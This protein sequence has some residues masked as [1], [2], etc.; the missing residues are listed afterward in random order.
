M[1]LTTAT[2]A[3][4]PSRPPLFPLGHLLAT[5]QVLSVLD[6]HGIAPLTLLQ[7]HVQ[8]DWGELV[9]EDQQV[10]QEALREGARLL[11][12]YHIAPGITVWIITEADRSVTNLLM[13]DDD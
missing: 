1:T 11:S 9:A 13:P 7:R 12:S 3:P 4:E 2:T 8:G 6:A 10:N 5:P